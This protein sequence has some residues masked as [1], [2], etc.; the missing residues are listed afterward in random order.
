MMQSTLEDS[1]KEFKAAAREKRA[2]REPKGKVEPGF[3]HRVLIKPSDV[4]GMAEIRVE[5]VVGRS[6]WLWGQRHVLKGIAD[7]LHEHQWTVL[8]APHGVNWPATDNPVIRLNFHSAQEYDFKGGWGSKNTEI[9]MPLDPIHMLYTRIG[10][11]R[12]DRGMVL[13]PR[14]AGMF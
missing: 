4:K 14:T 12:L 7:C 3:P 11:K 6:M 13:D 9:L 1:V 5:A 8:E 2:P 10:G